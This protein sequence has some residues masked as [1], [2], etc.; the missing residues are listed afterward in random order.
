MY[1]CFSSLFF[2]CNPGYGNRNIFACQKDTDH[3]KHPLH[4]AQCQIVFRSLSRVAGRC[5]GLHGE[6]RFLGDVVLEES[7]VSG[8]NWHVNALRGWEFCSDLECFGM[9]N[10]VSVVV[11]KMQGFSFMQDCGNYRICCFFLSFFFLFKNAV[12]SRFIQTDIFSLLQTLN[13][14]FYLTDGRI[15]I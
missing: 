9:I 8:I 14:A 11:F 4:Q 2:Y 3:L 6:G 10:S 15:H 1:F 13:V 5:A 7:G 12:V